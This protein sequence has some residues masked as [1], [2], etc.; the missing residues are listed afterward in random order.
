MCAV[1]SVCHDHVYANGEY[2]PLVT[3]ATKISIRPTNQNIKTTTPSNGSHLMNPPPQPPAKKWIFHTCGAK[4]PE[5]PTPSQCTNSYRNSNVN[6]S[7]G[8]R[9]PFKGIQMWHVPE[10]GTYRITAYGAAGGR[11]VLAMSRSLGVYLTGDFLLKK[12]DLLYILVGQQGEDACPNVERNQ[13]VPLIIAAGGGGRGYS[14][15]SDTQ[16]EQMDYNLSQPGRNGKSHSAVMEGDGE[17]IIT[18]V[19]N[20]SHCES[21]DCHESQ[22]GI[23]CYCDDALILAPDGLSCVNA[24]VYRRKHTE[25]QSI[26]LELQ[27]PDCKLSKLRASTIMT[28]Y[29]PNYCFGG[30]TTSVNDLKEVP[31]RNISLTS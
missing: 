1:R 23:I 6:M 31:R 12:G 10:S 2:P 16:L 28:D 11:S 13:Y 27:S 29:N 9:G 20:C 25:L 5:G 3:R 19:Q 17:V 18:P 7:V 24:T 26:Q 4:G 14:S 21:G 30:K 22:E 8:T 15:P